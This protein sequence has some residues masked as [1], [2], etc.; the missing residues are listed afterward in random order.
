MS[1]HP[2]ARNLEHALR[3]LRDAAHGVPSPADD[4]IRALRAADDALDGPEATLPV[5]VHCLQLDVEVRGY[6]ARVNDKLQL[7]W[8]HPRCRQAWREVH[9][10]LDPDAS[11]R[12]TTTTKIVFLPGAPRLPPLVGQHFG[13]LTILAENPRALLARCSCG[14][15]RWYIRRFI[16]TELV[17]TCPECAV[18]GN[19]KS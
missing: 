4:L 2:A 12:F 11:A 9:Q 6:T 14:V 18:R 8:L 13:Q 15:E 1:T 7:V 16:L 10:P 19:P 17:R 3:T 5:C